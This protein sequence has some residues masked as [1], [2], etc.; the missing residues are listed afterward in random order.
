MAAVDVLNST[1]PVRD[2]RHIVLTHLT[3]L[4]LKSLKEVLKRRKK[5]LFLPAGELTIHLSNPAAQFLNTSFGQP[6]MLLS[7]DVEFR[8]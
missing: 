3:P 4:R 7:P 1:V 6:A 2:I 5:N 8:V